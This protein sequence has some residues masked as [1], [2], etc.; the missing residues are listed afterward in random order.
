MIPTSAWLL[1]A[2]NPQDILLMLPSVCPS[3]VED[4]FLAVS[5]IT[6]HPCKI[7]ENAR[8]MS[9]RMTQHALSQLMT[10][11]TYKINKRYMGM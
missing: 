9:E 6:G 11:Q 1:P 7:L 10:F 3:K 5:A 4:I 2:T 8:W